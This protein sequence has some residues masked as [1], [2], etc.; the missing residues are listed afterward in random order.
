MNSGADDRLI[1]L[2]ALLLV[3]ALL[4]SLSCGS[5]SPEQRV[6]RMMREAGAA[7]RDRDMGRLDR[8][9]SGRY[10]DPL[11]NGKREVLAL[12]RFHLGQS[13]SI[14]LLERIRSIRQTGPSRVE[15]RLL[16]AA[17]AVPIRDLRELDQITADVLVFD[18]GFEKEGR[19][20]RVVEARWR[21]PGPADLF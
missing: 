8:M 6:R 11:G 2:S 16:V 12:L 9:V 7:A 18:V 19:H 4:L 20:W 21:R 15:A 10:R 1:R 3:P 5:V 17:A 14:H 13:G